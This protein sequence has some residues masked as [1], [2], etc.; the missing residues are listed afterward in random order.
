MQISNLGLVSRACLLS[1]VLQM[2]LN[3]LHGRSYFTTTHPKVPLENCCPRKDGVG[4][5]SQFKPLKDEL[6][7]LF[8]RIDHPLADYAAQTQIVFM[9]TI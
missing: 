6:H 2:A 5:G 8:W 3:K 4:E 1:Q 9:H 7:E